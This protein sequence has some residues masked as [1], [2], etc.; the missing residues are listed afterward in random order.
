MF[1]IFESLVRPTERPG[2]TPP[3]TWMA[4][5]WH[6]LRQT[7]GMVGV[8]FVTGLVVTLIDTLIPV[9]I[10]RMVRL[11]EAQDHAAAL[12]DAT[13][14]LVGMALLVPIG[15]PLVLLRDSLVRNNAVPAGRDRRAGSGDGGSYRRAADALGGFSRSPAGSPVSCAGAVVRRAGAGPAADRHAR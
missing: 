5:Y 15:R 6:D 11:M 14:M 8:M 1:A 7:K 13:P 12:I 10:G 9:F 4:F 3:Q 2:S